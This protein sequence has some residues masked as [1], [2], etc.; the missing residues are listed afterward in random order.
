M[1]AT[2]IHLHTRYQIGQVDPR[3]FGGFLE[4]IGRA[5]YQGVYEPESPHAD[6]DGFRGDVMNALQRLRMTAMR[7]P[8]GNFAS[9]YHW[10]DGVG[11]RADRPT[12]RE[13]AWQSL[14]PN[15]FGTDE[16]LALCRKMDW[17]PM[18]TV[19]LG[20]G[21]PEEARNWVEY[22]NC[23]TGSRYADLRAKNGSPE[24]YGVDLWCLGNEMD[25]PWQLGH[26][27]ADQYA[28]RAQ[29][30][31]KMMKDVDKALELVVCGSCTVGLPTYM[32]W[33]RQVLEHVGDFADYISLHRYV[34]NPTHDTPDY[35][36]I[37]NAIDTQIEEMDAVCR[38][39]Q[40]KRRSAKRAYLCFDEWNVWYKN[41]EM[42]GAGKFAPPLVEERYN[43]EDA[44]VVAAFL[45][46]F[47]RHAD[48][49]K[50]A[51]LAQIVNVIA[52]L[53]TRGD[54]LLIQPTFYPFEMFA[55]RR[56]GISL[57]IAVE[58]PIYESASYGT[59]SVIDASAVRDGNH[60]HLFLTNRSP[61][62]HAPVHINLAD[63]SITRIEDGEQ[64]AGNDPA[65]VNSFEEP[66]AVTPRPFTEGVITDGRLTL[67]LPPLSLTAM[68]V[69]LG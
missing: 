44:L 39:V 36:A 14:E 68:T 12:V 45:H 40:A 59:V 28:V 4:H 13:L 53:I 16:Y 54:D 67:D 2:T 29:Q 69:L 43:L 31:A 51:N 3:I 55:R 21:T 30:A 24:P 62:A 66:T 7:Y 10:M 1:D 19:N 65:A 20:T 32:E 56:T 33:D 25:G 35:L 23:P 50:I 27:P 38:F 18:I 48:V 8:G 11:P 6:A 58:G 47:L 34:G 5:V 49:L 17:T 37:S 22:C 52:P 41:H 42:D 9:G 63:A 57:R 46:S 60:V 61:D 64:L 26:V 15:T